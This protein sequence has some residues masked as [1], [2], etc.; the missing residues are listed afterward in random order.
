MNAPFFSLPGIVVIR[1]I[2]P[3]IKPVFSH[4]HMI[5]L[6]FSL[7]QLLS[8]SLEPANI[9]YRL[10]WAT[11]K[12]V[13]ASSRRDICGPRGAHTIGDFAEDILSRMK[14]TSHLWFC[15]RIPF[16]LDR[17][18]ECGNVILRHAMILMSNQCNQ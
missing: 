16:L 6:R 3:I 2:C 10:S 17:P 15:Y 5:S 9:A 11:K 12:S 8:S 14:N 4:A 1:L 18:Q 7:E 13:L